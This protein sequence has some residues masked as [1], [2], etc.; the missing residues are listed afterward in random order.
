MN[1]EQF[2]RWSA[3][4]TDLTEAQ[5]QDMRARLNGLSN[6]HASPASDWLFDGI[7]DS[8]KS[9]G[10]LSDLGK[11]LLMQGRAYKS[12]CKHTPGLQSELLK[13]LG[14]KPSRHMRTVLAQLSGDCLIAW[15]KY[16]V[17]SV[18]AAIVLVNTAHIME[19]LN[20]AFPGYIAAGMFH[21]A[22]SGK[23]KP[24]LGAKQ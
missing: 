1:P 24:P 15:C 22:L 10:L 19:A 12:Y 5:K 7:C 4:A 23:L 8:L 13:L 18:S 3:K 2:R 16:R 21:V 17:G 20:N 11:R 6:G 9:H 14:N